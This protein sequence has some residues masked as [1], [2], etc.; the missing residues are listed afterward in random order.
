MGESICAGENHRGGY[1]H[2]G[3]AAYS[4]VQGTQSKFY[5]LERHF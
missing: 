3:K 1:N 2:D 4:P 5:L